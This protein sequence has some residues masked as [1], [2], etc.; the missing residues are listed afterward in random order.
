MNSH[1]HTHTHMCTNTHTHTHTHT[2]V[3]AGVKDPSVMRPGH[4]H[5]LSDLSQRQRP[6]SRESI[7]V[8][9]QNETFSA[10]WKHL[11]GRLGLTEAELEQCE[12][13]GSGD[14]EEACFQMLTA[15]RNGQ[16]LQA[17][18]ARLTEAVVQIQDS[19]L[20]EIMNVACT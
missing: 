6:L 16:G 8:L 9:S 7:R 5:I 18:V 2:Q 11:A 10:H 17:T 3:G 1:T 12:E 19:S 4:H 14:R 13:K 20:L 15:W